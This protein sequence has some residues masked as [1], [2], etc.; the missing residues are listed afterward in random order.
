MRTHHLNCGS[1]SSPFLPHLQAV[2]HCLVVETNRGLVL[3]DTGF[4][5]TDYTDPTRRVR[6]FRR[7]LAVPDEI[8]SSASLQIA[9]LG[10]RVEDVQHVVLTHLHFDHA[11]GLPDFPDAQVHVFKT[12]FEAAMDPR[13]FMEHVGYEPAH[14]AHGPRWQIHEPKREQ[15]YGFEAIPIAKGLSPRILLIPLPGHTRGHSGV[16]IETEE[17]WLFD[18]GDAASP[19]HRA[20][21]VHQRPG[22]Y[23][24]LNLLPAT[25]APYVTGN[26]AE[27][28]RQLLAQHGDEIQLFSSHDPYSFAE[29]GVS[30]SPAAAGAASPGSGGPL[31]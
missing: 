6:V 18:C 26:H 22:T 16:A 31:P 1:I 14:W 7:L 13:G 9:A 28:L 25:I 30:A 4:G 19:F 5:T 11:G 17:G 23:Q 20:T 24:P 3:I 2:V 29:L 27:R 15:W 21:D 10:Y 12:E 8:E